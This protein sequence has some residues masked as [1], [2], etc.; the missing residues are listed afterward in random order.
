MMQQALQHG[1]GR[2]GFS[3]RH[4]DAIGRR[5]VLS[6]NAR[7]ARSGDNWEPDLAGMRNELIQLAHHLHHMALAEIY[8]DGESLPHLSRREIECLRWIAEGKTH[9]DIAIILDLSE[10]TVRGYLKDVRTKLNCVTLAQAV[11]N[12]SSLGLI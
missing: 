4:I 3:L 8:L 7:N 2:T 9:S 5:S 10:H 11:S 1:L 6:F 12:A